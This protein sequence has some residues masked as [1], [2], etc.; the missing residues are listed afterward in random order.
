MSSKKQIDSW[1]KTQNRAEVNALDID[2]YQEIG[3]WGISAVE[4]VEQIKDNDAAEI[5]VHLSSPGGDAFQGL[6]IMN[7]LRR[8]KAKINIEVDGLAASA[9]SIIAMGGDHVLMNEG[10]I[11][12]IHHPYTT[13]GGNAKE[14]RDA[15]EFL[16]K[17]GESMAEIYAN[18][19][20]HET[21]KFWSKLMD[22]STRFTA[23][24]AYEIGLA[25]ETTNK[26]RDH[27]PNQQENRINSQTKIDV[28]AELEKVS[29][30]VGSE[31]VNNSS[32][33]QSIYT[34][35]QSLWESLKR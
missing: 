26:K 16:D 24:E 21:V 1:F 4:L 6:A 27:E 8:H 5:N 35:T 22:K 28:Q 19:T 29:K 15:A 18:R 33:N 13:A 14:L 32:Q 7:A 3:G 31:T 9:A 10:S 20:G 34:D 23:T 17:L 30:V 11:I 2:I 25:D 12:M